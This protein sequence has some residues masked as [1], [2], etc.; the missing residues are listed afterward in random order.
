MGKLRHTQGWQLKGS[1]CLGGS[2][3]LAGFVR[4][5]QVLMCPLPDAAWLSPGCSF[6]I[7][8]Q[9]AEL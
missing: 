4:A 5:G 8:V 7:P 3:C 9:R 2:D 1:L 6:G